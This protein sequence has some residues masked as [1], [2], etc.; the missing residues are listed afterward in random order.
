M[1]KQICAEW[2]RDNLLMSE[3][4]ASPSPGRLRRPPSPEGERLPFAVKAHE[5][6]EGKKTEPGRGSALSPGG[7]GRRE[8]SG[9]GG[10]ARSHVPVI[11]RHADV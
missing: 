1:R 4:A 5:R 11:R 9:E 10:A 8:A 3:R 2:R 7:R 6:G